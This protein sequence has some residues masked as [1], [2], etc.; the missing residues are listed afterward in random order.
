MTFFDKSAIF[1]QCIT[2][3]FCRCQRPWQFMWDF[4]LME[5]IGELRKGIKSFIQHKLFGNNYGLWCAQYLN[6]KGTKLWISLSAWNVPT[7]LAAFL[8]WKFSGLGRSLIVSKL[9]V[10]RTTMSRNSYGNPKPQCRKHNYYSYAP[11]LSTVQMLFLFCYYVGALQL[12]FENVS[13]SVKSVVWWE[14]P[15]CKLLLQNDSVF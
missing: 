5:K 6:V 11:F 2:K 14:L 9:S 4:T 12:P 15:C 3:S 13:N 8:S 7:S 1:P 10:I